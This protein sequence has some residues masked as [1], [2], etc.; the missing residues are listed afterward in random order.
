MNQCVYIANIILTASSKRLNS[1]RSI[2][3]ALNVI[4]NAECI[5]HT[6]HRTSPWWWFVTNN[7]KYKAYLAHF[8]FNS[9]SFLFAKQTNQQIEFDWTVFGVG[10]VFCYWRTFLHLFWT[11]FATNF[12][13]FWWMMNKI[14]LNVCKQPPLAHSNSFNGCLKLNLLL[15]S[16]TNCVLSECKWI[17]RK[18]KTGNCV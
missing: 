11:T 15:I 4:E 13:L 17:S 6:A 9:H 18:A 14:W 12:Y 10:F 1:W 8:G 5:A 2:W 7:K 16:R 3:F